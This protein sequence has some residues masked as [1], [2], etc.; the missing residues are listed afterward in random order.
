M[1][2]VS[3]DITEGILH[4]CGGHPS[5]KYHQDWHKQYSP[6]MW[7]SSYFFINSNDSGLVFSTYVEV[8][9]KEISDFISSVGIL[10][11]CGG[12]PHSDRVAVLD[13]EYSPRMWRSS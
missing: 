11:V 5:Y 7:R 9:L 1:F 6:R 12:H 10:H 13:Y 8:I 3:I 2:T 4:V